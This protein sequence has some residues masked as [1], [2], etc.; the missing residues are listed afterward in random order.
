MKIAIIHDYLN[1]YGGAERVLEIFME[2]FPEAPIYTMVS[3]LSKM[4][5]K[6]Q[7]A[8]IRTS[9]IQKIPFSKNHY[10]KMLSLFPIAV[11]QFDLRGYDVILS[12]SSA[13]AKGVITNPNQ[14]HICYCYTPMRYVWD[15]YHQYMNEDITNPIFKFALPRVL[16]K[17]RMW[18]QLTAQR[19]DHFIADS[20]SISRR[21]NKYYGRDSEVIY[22][23]VNLDQFYRSDTIG[24]YYLIVSRLIP[25]KRIDI[26]IQAFNELNLPL[27]IIG[28]GYDR[29]RLEA[30]A[31]PSVKLLG[32]QS[33][34]VIAEYYS[35]CKCFILGGEE[36]FGITPLEAQASGRPVIAYRKGGALETVK[37]NQTGLF[38]DHST[39]ESVIAAVRQ[40]ETMNFDSNQIQ[41]HANEFSTTTFKQKI[42]DFIQE[43]IER[44]ATS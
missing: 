27:V 44:K 22:P 17:I 15:L 38:F 16:H 36:D 26:V 30:M 3:D 21:I 41:A 9:F 2:M 10:K 25:Y 11:E 24:D 12:S 4:P 34:E 18:D 39:P 6:F 28:D 32:F 43:K 19:V 35:K 40:I 14:L 23:P 7:K 5:E 1:Q 20:K 37:E 31:G 29:K 42:M 33:D 13:F 8:D